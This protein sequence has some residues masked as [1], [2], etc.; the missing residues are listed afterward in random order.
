MPLKNFR[1]NIALR[2]SLMLL[3][4]FVLCWLLLNSTLYATMTVL[5][6]FIVLQ[7]YGLVRF[8]E[9]TNRHLSRFFDAIKHADFSQH[10]SFGRIGPSFQELSGSFDEVLQ[11]LQKSRVDTEEQF[12]YLQTVIQHVGIGLIVFHAGGRVELIN[13]AAKK[14]LNIHQLKDIHALKNRHDQLPAVLLSLGHGQKTL[15]KMPQDNELQQ[16]ALSATGFRIRQ[17]D[18]RLISIQNIQGEL[19]EKEMESWQNLIR[20]LTHEIMNSI[21]PISSLALTARDLLQSNDSLQ[22]IDDI[23][24]AVQTIHSRSEGLLKFVDSYRSLTRLPRPDF[25]IIPVS[26][27]FDSM[28]RLL[29]NTLTEKG[30]ELS[31]RIDPPGLELTADPD[32]IEQALINLVQNA[33]SAVEGQN[34]RQITLRAGLN[35]RGR[36]YIAVIDHGPGIL[37]EV[38]EKIFIPFFTTRKEGT[39]IGLSLCRQIMRLHRGS[40]SVQ[41]QPNIATTFTLRF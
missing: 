14:I 41:S 12:R 26:S 8:A 38:Q 6:L 24:S 28:G 21:T 18:L 1:L 22:H 15:F 25:R 4:V 35:K 30:V 20:V 5:A 32:L 27:L 33:C 17:R 7:V 39:G 2:V 23:R 31:F 13:N 9:Q 40:I 11:A 37:P 34:D 10:H 3:S 36:L 19:D 16:L 29:E